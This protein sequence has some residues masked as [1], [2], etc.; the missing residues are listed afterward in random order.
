MLRLGL[1]WDTSGRVLCF[2]D[3]LLFSPACHAGTPAITASLWLAP[4]SAVVLQL[5][6]AREPVVPPARA[7]GC[8]P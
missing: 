8:P 3:C 7:A 1:G 5:H 2:E 4:S 6:S